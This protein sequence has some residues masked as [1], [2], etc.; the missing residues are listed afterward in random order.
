LQAL[1]VPTALELRNLIL[2]CLVYWP[3]KQSAHFGNGENAMARFSK[4]RSAF[5]PEALARLKPIF[6][7]VWKELISE[8]VF[9][10]PSFDEGSTRTRLAYKVLTFAST[11]WTEI[12]MRQLLLRAFRNEVARLHSGGHIYQL[13]PL[14]P[15]DRPKSAS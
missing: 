6:D 4:P 2:L 9:E 8:G 1:L 15:A 3:L 11:D 14:A 10:L 5:G 12:Q 13:R 7:D